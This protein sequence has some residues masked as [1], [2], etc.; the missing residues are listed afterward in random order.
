MRVEGEPK[1]AIQPLTNAS[2]TVSA[3]MFVMGMASGQRVKRSTQV[4][5]ASGVENVA[6][7]VTVRLW[8]LDLWDCRHDCAHLR[9]SDLMF[10]QTYRLVMRRSVART[11]GWER[12]WRLSNT[13]RLYRAG[14]T[15]HGTPLERSY[16]IVTVEAGI[17]TLL[18][19]RD[20]ED[21]RLESS[22]SPSCALAISSKC[23]SCR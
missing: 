6:R 1:R 23:M 2:A 20:V 18:T 10:G 13:A 11:P 7:G 16:T 8:I 4:R 22:W 9:T 5:N 21:E 17:G 15:G 14:T 12:E 19:L 3:V